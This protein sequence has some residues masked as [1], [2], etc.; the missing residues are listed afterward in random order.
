MGCA[1]PIPLR[2]HSAKK[3]LIGKGPESAL[4]FMAGDAA[5]SD[6]L[7]VDDFRGSELQWKTL[8]FTGAITHIVLLTRT[9][10]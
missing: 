5:R 9:K 3:P 4:F 1:G 8:R 2:T 10:A 6:S 7:P